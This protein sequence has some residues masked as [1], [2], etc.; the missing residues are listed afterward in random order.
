MCVSEIECV[1]VKN[2]TLFPQAAEAPTAAGR[3]RKKVSVREYEFTKF[4]FFIFKKKNTLR[5]KHF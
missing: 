3:R 5:V 4:F 1:C 2:K